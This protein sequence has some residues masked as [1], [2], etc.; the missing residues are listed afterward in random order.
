MAKTTRIGQVLVEAGLIDQDQLQKCLEEQ[1]RS[2]KDIGRLLIE[3]DLVTQD[4]LTRALAKHFRVPGVDLDKFS[5]EEKVVRLV[6]EE[7]ARKHTVVPLRKEG[8]TLR[9]AMADPASVSAIDEIRFITRLKVEPVVCSEV[10]ISA[11]I[12]SCYGSEG[13]EPLTS[14]V[15]LEIVQDEPDQVD[16]EIDQIV[17]K[18]AFDAAPIVKLV[19]GLVISAVQQEATHIHL[20]PD[21]EGIRV[22]FRIDGQLRDVASVPNKLRAALSSR[23]KIISDLNIA[24][25]RKPQKGRVTMKIGEDTFGITTFSLPTCHG[26]RFLLEITDPRGSLRDIDDLGFLPDDTEKLKRSLHRRSGL[27]LITG[28]RRSGK[29]TTLYAALNHLK[30]DEVSILTAEGPIEWNLTGVSQTAFGGETG[31]SCSAALEAMIQQDPDILMVTEIEEHGVAV[32]VVRTALDGYRLLSSLDTKDAPSALVKLLEL[33]VEPSSV[34]SAVPLVLSQRLLRKICEACK[35]EASHSEREQDE[36]RGLVE[37]LSG[38][39]GLVD[40]RLRYYVGDGCDQCGGTG[41]RGRIPVCEILEVSE[42][43]REALLEDPSW[44]NLRGAAVAAGMETLGERALGRAAAGETSL[45]ECSRIL[46]ETAQR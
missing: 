18:S 32:T 25:R 24:E 9:V 36:L 43:I 16:E 27:V 41:Y 10:A 37:S 7:V 23:V 20:V 33:G 1:A 19:N 31:L 29:T 39:R 6:P 22:R 13:R 35:V 44:E 34:A 30:H 28:P 42:S 12:D 17:E 2:G 45:I 11:A 5:I 3:R 15:D 46:Q 4:A 14:D 40:Q 38:G 26:E 21:E 8:D